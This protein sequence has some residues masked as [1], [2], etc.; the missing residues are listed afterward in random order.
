MRNRRILLGFGLLLA[1]VG[2]LGGSVAYGLYYRSDYYRRKVERALT[3]FFGLPTDVAAVR[4]A[5]LQS[6]ILENVEM[7]LPERRARIFWSPRAVWD[8]SP[9]DSGGTVLHLYNATLAIGSEQWEADDYMRVLRA[10]LLHNF[11]DLNIRRVEF[12]NTSITR[13]HRDFRIRADGV[14]GR[15]DFD[16]TGH[17]Q[18]V[19]VTHSLNGVKTADPIRIR[20]TLDPSNDEDFLPEV[21]LEVPSLPLAALGLSQAVGSEV[22]QGSFAGRIR[23]E[24]AT[25]ADIVELNGQVQQIRLDEIT[26]R[27]QGG[28]LSGLVDLTLHR[29][30][31]RGRELEHLRFSG[32]VRE[33]T[34]DPLL[35]RFGL[36]AIGGKVNLQ[37]LNGLFQQD[38]IESLS[39]AGHWHG[40]RLAGLSEMALG[41]PSIDGQLDVRIASLVIKDNQL[42]SGNI[43]VDATPPAGKPGTIDR[44]L[45][46][47]LLEKYMGFKV[48]AVLARMLPAHVEFVRAEA[49]LLLDGQTLTILNVPR[50]GGGALLTVRVSGR[51]VPLVRSID[52][53][54][55]LAPLLDRARNQAH[56]WKQS[57]T[58][59]RATQPAR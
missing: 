49:K 55:D 2:V 33:L 15:V 45:L 20:A 13:P 16:G 57:W 35:S 26:G 48:P 9:N 11:S 6:R 44:A 14:D 32:E 21:V 29:A 12:H 59:R 41:A 25:G 8:A 19:L 38:R 50:P 53:V 58:Q 43:D 39:L 46:L 54:F 51:E 40:G 31:L 3:A 56:G 34:V 47:D 27:M 1:V 24:Q 36:P 30:V 52:Q 17:G 23:L 7:W 18:A 5:T 42:A 4:P 22:T 37:V 28:P 10:S